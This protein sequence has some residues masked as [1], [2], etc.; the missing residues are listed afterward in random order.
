LRLERGFLRCQIG[1]G[2]FDL[3]IGLGLEP[4]LFDF[5]QVQ[6]IVLPQQHVRLS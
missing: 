3:G 1:L 2:G 4:E 5:I 6:I